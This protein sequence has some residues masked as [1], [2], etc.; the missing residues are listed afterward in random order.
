MSTTIEVTA[1]DIEQGLTACLVHHEPRQ[2]ACPFCKAI[3]RYVKP[4]VLVSVGNVCIVFRF[5][6]QRIVINQPAS[7]LHRR[8]AFDE[9]KTLE[10]FSFD[11]E[12]PI[13]AKN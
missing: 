7:M 10:P 13:E 8:I 4:F 12:I 6:N 2:N 1:D 9:G 3:K 11:L 5:N